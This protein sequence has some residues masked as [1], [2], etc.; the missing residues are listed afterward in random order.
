MQ[1][2]EVHRIYQAGVDPEELT[3]IPLDEQGFGLPEDGL[4]CLEGFAAANPAACRAFAQA[5]L[6]GWKMA[7]QNPDEALAAVLK[8]ARTAHL[9]MNEAH[10][11][12]MLKTMLESIV[13]PGQGGWNLG[14][15]SRRDY[16]RSAQILRGQGVIS[17][18]PS[19][20]ALTL[21]GPGRAP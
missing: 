11:R 20:E 4:Y 2:N 13:P 8:R 1:Y 18:P 5:S 17:A 9:P 10:Q 21:K 3:V 14:E 15:L 12:W 19:Y 6:E 7:A 16:D